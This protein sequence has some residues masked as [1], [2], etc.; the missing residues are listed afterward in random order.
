MVNKD[1]VQYSMPS[2]SLSP[3][4]SVSQLVSPKISNDLSEVYLKAY[5]VN[6]SPIDVIRFK[7]YLAG[8]PSKLFLDVLDL[9]KNGANL[10]STLKFDPSRPAPPKSKVHRNLQRFGRPVCLVRVKNEQDCWPP[11]T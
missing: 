11:F 1:F 3:K 7:Q 9:V 6:A 2:F 10:H 8:Y 4:K 5:N